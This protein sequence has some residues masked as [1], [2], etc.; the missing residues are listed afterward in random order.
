MKPL[1]L[2]NNKLITATLT[3]S[4]TE[5]GY[6]VQNVIDFRPY[7]FWK[8]G[9]AGSNFVRGYWAVAQSVSNVSVVGHN[10]FSVGATI[11]IEYSSNGSSWS[12][13]ASLTPA[14]DDAI[15]LNFASQTANYWRIRIENTLGQPYI[16]VLIFGVAIEFEW[17]PD[18]PFVPFTKISKAEVSESET[19]NF[20]GASVKF[21]QYELNHIFSNF[22]AAWYDTYFEPFMTNHGELYKPFVYAWDLT[23]KPKEVF[24]VTL[25][26]DN[27][28]GDQISRLDYYDLITLNMIGRR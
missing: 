23:T 28:R 3:G 1:L 27:A 19:G 15:L 21:T 9:S 13:A 16:G 11:Y 26:K 24:F 4:A 25:K 17:P 10:F 14:S 2:Y 18:A 6:D 20:L 8:A 7:S 12:A 5:S 22:T